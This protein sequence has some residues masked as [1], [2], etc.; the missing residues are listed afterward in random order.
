[1]NINLHI[2]KSTSRLNNFVDQLESTA[3]SAIKNVTRLIPVKN[4]DVVLYDIFDYS[5]VERIYGYTPNAHLVFIYLNPEVKNFSKIIEEDLEESIAH[6]LHHALRWIN[7]G[8]GTTLLEA[9]VTEGLAEH[10]GDEVKSKSFAPWKNPYT[11]SE[12][13]RVIKLAQKE[14]NSKDYNHDEWFFGQNSKLPMWT[15]Y[16]LGYEIVGQYLK[17]HPDKKASVL[18]DAKAEIFI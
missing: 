10:F 6:E 15:G 2:L 9:L 3:N 14:F 16:K 7:P 18:Y 5:K 4:V 12:L 11:K 17:K 8:Y 13:E 1:M